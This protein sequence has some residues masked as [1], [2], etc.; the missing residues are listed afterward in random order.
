M[1]SRP[2][3]RRTNCDGTDNVLASTW[4]LLVLRV[5]LAD[6]CSQIRLVHAVAKADS[7][8]LRIAPPNPSRDD[9]RAIRPRENVAR[10]VEKEAA[11]FGQFDMTLRAPQ[12]ARLQLGL[13]LADLVT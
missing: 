7:Q 4:D 13:E 10:F 5:E 12:Q 9:G 1:S 6:H 2:S 3:R 11:R 8:A